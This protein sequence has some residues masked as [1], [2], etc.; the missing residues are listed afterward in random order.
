MELTPTLSYV[1]CNCHALVHPSDPFTGCAHHPGEIKFFA[2]ESI[3]RYWTC[4][5]AEIAAERVFGCVDNSCHHPGPLPSVEARPP[6]PTP[7]EKEK[8]EESEPELD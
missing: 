5:G 8:D 7:G 6:P 4:C 3:R 2:N 1:C